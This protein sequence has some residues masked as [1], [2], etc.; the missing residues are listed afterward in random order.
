MPRFLSWSVALGLVA[1]AGAVAW[2]GTAREGARPVEAQVATITMEAPTGQPSTSENPEEVTAPPRPRLVGGLPTRLVIDSANIETSIDEVGIIQSEDG[3]LQWET[4]QRAAGHNLDSARP[5]QPGNMVLTGHVAVADP[6]DVAVFANLT[7]VRMGDLVQVY[8]GRQKFTYKV[9]EI[10][11]VSPDEISVLE[12]DH[13]AR[14][15]LITCTI[16]LEG[17]LIVIASLVS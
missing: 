17:R 8:A 13:R 14:L 5:G 2:Y 15:T 10:R 12:G 3:S 11:T 16:D 9:T 1:G 7:A 4:S 6:G